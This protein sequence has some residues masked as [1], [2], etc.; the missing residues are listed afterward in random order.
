MT[1]PKPITF[2]TD[3]LVRTQ[4]LTPLDARLE[5][6]SAYIGASGTEVYFSTI[7]E[8]GSEKEAQRNAKAAREAAIK[9]VVSDWLDSVSIAMSFVYSKYGVKIDY[10]DKHA[11][12]LLP[13][14]TWVDAADRVRLAEA[15]TASTL[16]ALD[17][18]ILYH[19]TA[20]KAV[21]DWLR[22]LRA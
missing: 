16:M 18:Y 5:E 21:Q 2:S 7:D 3:W 15:E 4:K 9:G 14:T 13:I 22:F 1:P 20:R 10:I 12:R 6:Q 17:E 8:G 11:V 19:G